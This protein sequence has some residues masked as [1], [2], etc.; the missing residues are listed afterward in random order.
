MQEHRPLPCVHI[1]QSSIRACVCRPSPSPEPHRRTASMRPAQC[2][3]RYEASAGTRGRHQQAGIAA[4]HDSDSRLGQPHK[5]GQEIAS[6]AGVSLHNERPSRPPLVRVSGP[7]AFFGEQGLYPQKPG[8]RCELGW[9]GS[10]HRCAGLNGQSVSAAG[11][12]PSSLHI[13]Q[14]RPLL[15]SEHQ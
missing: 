5:S 2:R 15:T 11:K 3:G 7:S 4:K 10:I 14:A 13:R 8:R 9:Y 6:R 1:R 12:T